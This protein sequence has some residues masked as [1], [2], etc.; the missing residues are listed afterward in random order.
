MLR[1][2]QCWFVDN[3][4]KV[5]ILKK[6]TFYYCIFGMVNYLQTIPVV[7]KHMEFIFPNHNPLSDW[8]DGFRKG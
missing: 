1:R 7:F 5:L 4:T 8:T 6:K 3:H 2:G